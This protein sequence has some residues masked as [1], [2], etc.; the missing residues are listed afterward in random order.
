MVLTVRAEDNLAA[1]RARSIRIP[2][3]D[4]AEVVARRLADQLRE[5][6]W[7]VA[8]ADIAVPSTDT[9][10]KE[11]WTALR[12]GSGY[13]TT[14]YRVA[15]DNGLPETSAAVW[16]LPSPETW[17]ALEITGTATDPAVAVICTVRSESKP[18]APVPGLTT[19]RGRQ[20]PA[21]DALSP[22]SVRRLDA[23]PVPISDE[24]LTNLGWPVEPR[25]LTR[26]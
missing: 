20:R 17:T 13:V 16:A 2:L 7:N 15:V 22:L 18:S 6:G 12:D 19:L 26:T 14:A 4:T 23:S 10:A 5:K 24:L 25:A 3:R 21:I 1:L 11:T 9:S 8:I